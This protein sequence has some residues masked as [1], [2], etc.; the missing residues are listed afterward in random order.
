MMLEDVAGN[1]EH[2]QIGEKQTPIPPLTDWDDMIDLER[3]GVP[4]VVPTFITIKEFCI[5]TDLRPCPRG[6]EFLEEPARDTPH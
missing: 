4:I 2:L 3:T 1:A 5:C 6:I